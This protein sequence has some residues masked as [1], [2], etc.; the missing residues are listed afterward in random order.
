MSGRHGKL[1]RG[2]MSTNPSVIVGFG[3]SFYLTTNG[4]F[5]QCGRAPEDNQHWFPLRVHNP[6]F[7]RPE[8]T[9]LLIHM[10]E[11]VG[12]VR[13]ERLLT[14][15]CGDRTAD[16]RSRSPIGVQALDVSGLGQD[17]TASRSLL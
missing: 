1:L 15:I 7:R 12:G 9:S 10:E 3:V 8:T 2:L 17:L 11:V 13:H 14:H 4:Q 5:M 6:N 16:G